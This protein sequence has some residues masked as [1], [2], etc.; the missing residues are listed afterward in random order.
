MIISFAKPSRTVDLIGLVVK[1]THIKCR[2]YIQ[3][4]AKIPDCCT[5]ITQLF[6]SAIIV[7]YRKITIDNHKLSLV[8]IN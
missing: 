8:I 4:V 6:K 2:S 5:I 3:G 7:Y 1:T